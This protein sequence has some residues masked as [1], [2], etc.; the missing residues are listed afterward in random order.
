M[1]RWPGIEHDKTGQPRCC[2][3]RGRCWPRG[4]A[5]TWP[6]SG[7]CGSTSRSGRS[8]SATTRSS[9]GSGWA[10]P[11]S[12]GDGR[13]LAAL[14]DRI[15]VAGSGD[16]RRDRPGGDP[17]R[18]SGDA[19]QRRH[20]RRR[21]ALL[22]RHDG[23]RRVAA[24]T[25]GALYRFDRTGRCTRSSPGSRSPT[26]SAG[27]R[28]GRA[29]TTS[30]RWPSGSTRSTSTRT[31]GALHERRPWVTIPEAD[32]GPDGLAV[33]DQGGVWVALFGGAAVR[34]YRPDGELDGVIELPVSQV[35]SCCFAGERLIITTASRDVSEPQAGHLFVAETGFS[36]P[37]GPTVL[38]GG[39]K[40]RSLG[41]REHV[42]PV[43]GEDRRSR[44]SARAARRRPCAPPA[45]PR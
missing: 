7:C 45:A 34:R 31:R 15:V 18:A 9:W 37:P 10:R 4:R 1:A 32:G 27:A 44:S 14:E 6:R 11:R 30:T 42:R 23:A 22:D 3:R 28:R 5:G 13:L 40:H 12:P 25:G 33:D 38:V 35:T 24:C 29:C 17:A 21:G 16:G 26:G 43:A 2:S 20:L 36:G 39:S 8:T 19:H 41:R